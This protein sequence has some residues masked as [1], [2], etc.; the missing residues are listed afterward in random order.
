GKRELEEA[1]AL[2]ARA[3]AAPGPDRF[4]ALDTLA[5]IQ[6]ARGRCDEATASFTS[7]LAEEGIPEEA[8]AGLEEGVREPR[9]GC[10]PSSQPS[11]RPRSWATAL[12]TLDRS[13]ESE[14]PSTARRCGTRLA[15]ACSPGAGYALRAVNRVADHHARRRA[16]HGG[17]DHLPFRVD[18]RIGHVMDPP[19]CVY[20]Q[21]QRPPDRAV[22]A[23]CRQT[24]NGFLRKDTLARGG[25]ESRDDGCGRRQPTIGNRNGQRQ[26]SA[27]GVPWEI[28]RVSGPGEDVPDDIGPSGPGTLAREAVVEDRRRNDPATPERVDDQYRAIDV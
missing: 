14:D 6:L 16:L 2:A 9:R 27:L 4:E 23:R 15:R 21:A 24:R 1:E 25:D 12:R 19:G 20:G 18:E 10:A 17:L 26:S 22:S 3:A 5:R 7:A 8:R 13:A 28:G 11:C